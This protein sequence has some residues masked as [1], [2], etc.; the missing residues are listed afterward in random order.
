MIKK[1]KKKK[2][3]FLAY[4]SFLNI[5][6]GDIVKRQVRLEKINID[7]ELKKFDSK[8]I[9]DN[10]KVIEKI[11]T[12]KRLMLYHLI[13]HGIAIMITSSYIIFIA[14]GMEVPVA[15]STIASIVIGF[16]FARTLFN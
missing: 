12:Q 10:I 2:K 15:F 6:G 8:L 4:N 3:L 7:L 5:K 14:F 13:V 1:V 9:D 11:S 16:Y